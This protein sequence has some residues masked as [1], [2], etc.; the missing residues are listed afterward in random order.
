MA[1]LDF[2]Y[3][4]SIEFMAA[5]NERR[6]RETVWNATWQNIE[7]GWLKEGDICLKRVN[8]RQILLPWTTRARR[9]RWRT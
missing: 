5:R 8:R 3:T 1:M 7:R 2:Y 9:S 4:W 6:T